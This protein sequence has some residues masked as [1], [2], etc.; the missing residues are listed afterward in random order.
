[1][2]GWVP[3]A[4]RYQCRAF[5][6]FR[7]AGICIEAFILET[8][9]KRGKERGREDRRKE[10]ERKPFSLISPAV[11][12]PKPWDSLGTEAGIPSQ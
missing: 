5:Y 7:W 4:D 2:R 9:G 3:E 6:R 8:K 11:K 10:G 12:I 1:M